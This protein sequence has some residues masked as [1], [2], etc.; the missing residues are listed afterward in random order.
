MFCPRIYYKLKTPLFFFGG[1]ILWF[2]KNGDAAILS[3]EKVGL[4]GFDVVSLI[5]FEKL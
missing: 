2:L 5:I 3:M 4:C 1:E